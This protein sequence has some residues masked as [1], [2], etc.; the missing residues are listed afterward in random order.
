MARRYLTEIEGWALFC[1][2]LG[3]DPE[4]VLST[5]PAADLSKALHDMATKFAGTPDEADAYWRKK[6][7]TDSARL[8]TVEEIADSYRSLFRT[9][10]ETWH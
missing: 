1:R 6:R 8:P 4:G 5:I 9:I 3:I 2:E 7:G 10:E